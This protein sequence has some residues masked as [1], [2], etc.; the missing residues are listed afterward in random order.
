MK[1]KEIFSKNVNGRM[2]LFVQDKGIFSI[3]KSKQIRNKIVR[4]F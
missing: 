1:T 4:F 2:L 3:S